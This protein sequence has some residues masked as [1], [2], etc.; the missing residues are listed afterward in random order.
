MM[1]K[2]PVQRQ[3]KRDPNDRRISLDAAIQ[4]WRVAQNQR[5]GFQGYWLQGGENRLNR[6][7]GNFFAV[8][9]QKNFSTIAAARAALVRIENGDDY[10]AVLTE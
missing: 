8:A 6:S 7:G 4:T 1:G 9:Q 5:G 10:W 3:P 2:N